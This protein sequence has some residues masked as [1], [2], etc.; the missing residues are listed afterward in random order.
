MDLHCF[1]KYLVKK[2]KGKFGCEK[3]H[4]ATICRGMGCRTGKSESHEQLQFPL[5]SF[6]SILAGIVDMSHYYSKVDQIGGRKESEYRETILR[7]I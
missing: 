1:G 2:I 5:C 3:R 4:T 6:C 7:E